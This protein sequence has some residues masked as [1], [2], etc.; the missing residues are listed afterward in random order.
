MATWPKARVPEPIGIEEGKE[1]PRLARHLPVVVPPLVVLAVCYRILFSAE[2]IPLHG[3]MGFPLTLQRYGDWFQN[4]WNIH[5]NQSN[6]EQIDRLL[7]IKPVLFVLGLLH[8]SPLVLAKVLVIGLLLL[9]G[10][11]AFILARALVKALVPDAQPWVS[12]L[13]G[14]AAGTVYEFGPSVMY[15]A[16]AYFYLLAYALAPLLILLMFRSASRK[17]LWWLSAAT[18]GLL[19]SIAAASPQHTAFLGLGLSCLAIIVMHRYGVRRGLPGVAL[20]FITFIASS[21]YW[22]VPTVPLAINGSLSPGYLPS[23]EDTVA[24]S[25]NATLANAL[26]GYPEWLVWWSPGRFWPPAVLTILSSCRFILPACA[27]LVAAYAWRGWVVRSAAIVGSVL[28]V[29]SMGAASPL[30]PAYRFAMFHIPALSNIGW[31]IRAPEKFTGYL[32]LV[33]VV[34]GV[35]GAALILRQNR[36]KL[37]IALVLV[38]PA[39]VFASTLPKNLAGFGDKYV[40]ISVPKEYY[41]VSQELASMPGAT[42]WLAP[43]YDATKGLG[44]NLAYTW[45]PDK[46][47]PGFIRD[48]LPGNTFAAYNFTN[49][50]AQEYAYLYSHPENLSRKLA[51]LGIANIVLADDLVG[52][53]AGFLR[54]QAYLTSDPSIVFVKRVGADLY[55]YTLLQ[56]SAATTS[57]FIAVQGGRASQEDIYRRSFLNM[58]AAHLVYAEQQADPSW[59]TNPS[60]SNRLPWL[61]D[62]RSDIDVAMDS[63]AQKYGVSFTDKPDSSQLL[64]GWGRTLTAMP[65]SDFW[66][67]H[68]YLTGLLG[69]PDAWDFDFGRG[70]VYSASKGA[71]VKQTV[72]VPAGNYELLI[73]ALTGARS[74]TVAVSIGGLRRYVPLNSP[75]Q[76]SLR[77]FDLGPIAL[78]NP[79]SSVEIQ[80]GSDQGIVNM[81]AVVPATEFRNELGRVRNLFQTDGLSVVTHD[82]VNQPTNQYLPADVYK[83][84]GQGSV[85]LID[86]QDGSVAV[87]SDGL[88]RIDRPGTFAIAPIDANLA[89]LSMN[90]SDWAQ[91]QA[92]VDGFRALGSDAWQET[93]LAAGRSS[94]LRS[95]IVTLPTLCQNIV[96]AG[97]VDID[98]VGSLSANIQFWGPTGSLIGT[99]QMVA[100]KTGSLVGL[101][102]GGTAQVPP[103]ARRVAAVLEDRNPV[104]G[105]VRNPVV[106][107]F[108]ANWTKPTAAGLGLAGTRRA[109]PSEGSFLIHDAAYDPQWRLVSHQGAPEQVG[110][111]VDGAITLFPGAHPG[112]EV[113]Y[114]PNESL[115]MGW[116]LTALAMSIV[117]IV[118]FLLAYQEFKLGKLTKRRRI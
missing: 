84:S 91:P 21:L 44:G 22:I 107:L 41:Q 12:S 97:S 68:D 111:P 27:L 69:V 17:R 20:F 80:N 75:I 5:G 42:L 109:Q 83:V 28:V 25:R 65:T 115:G 30:Q 2:G 31:F 81:V 95:P 78:S 11:T 18:G 114:A 106:R 32:W 66:P 79:A 6:L 37:A 96:A 53:H 85:R 77:W 89:L 92:S 23:W 87:P 100:A 50:F 113:V 56:G 86:L 112:D 58:P 24:F 49:P 90:G 76:S 13:V 62:D 8:A 99:H 108:C 116:K 102:V 73:R 54:L 88:V 104:G 105:E 82:L 34:L 1:S 64:G 16:S 26:T 52:G 48:S 3:D 36:S 117:L 47:A 51:A 35:V 40:P 93:T 9:S 59:M 33:F 71:T 67:W 43:Y 46:M 14:A 103:G 45:A 101:N 55:V 110:V 19:F 63:F 10:L 29:G 118:C 7:F 57:P 94:Y 38:I 60:Q 74:S 15:L 70:V 98:R 61:L 4:M 72:Q 39:A